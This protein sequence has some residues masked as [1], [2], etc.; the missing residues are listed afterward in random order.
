MK[1]KILTMSALAL[2]CSASVAC[3]SNANST[4]DNVDTSNTAISQ[5]STTSKNNINNNNINTNITEEKAKEIALNHANLSQ[6]DVTFI[7]SNLD[8][9][10]GMKAYDIEF[11]S[12]NQEYDYKINVNDGSIIEYDMDIENYSIPQANTST[13]SNTSNAQ[14][15]TEEK[16]KE[17]ALNHANLSQ[18]QVSYINANLDYDDG[19]KTYEVDFYVNNVEHSYEINAVDGSIVSYEVDPN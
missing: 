7:K 14:I 3:N 11:Y 8:Y 15:I 10:D 19:I 9:D 5:E 1:R 13:T 17:I 16:A 2:F 12:N 18:N 6:N 4:N